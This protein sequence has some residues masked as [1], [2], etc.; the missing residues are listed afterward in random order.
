MT[1]APLSNI[2][3]VETPDTPGVADSAPS[4]GQRVGHYVA[5][6]VFEASALALTLVTGL[7]YVVGR[8]YL[9]G[10]EEAAGVPGLMFRRDLSDVMLGGATVARVWMMPVL[11]AVAPFLIMWV[12]A[13][14]PEWMMARWPFLQLK[15]WYRRVRRVYRSGVDQIRLRQR[16]ADAAYSATR[17]LKPQAR[18]ECEAWSRWKVLG[19]R[20]GRIAER[21][22]V[23]R[24]RRAMR[25]V[26]FVMLLAVVAA[27]A[28]LLG[29]T[30]FVRA[31]LDE[32]RRMGRENFAKIYLAVTGRVPYQYGDGLRDPQELQGWAC[33]GRELLSYY[34]AVT[35]GNSTDSSKSSATYY[36]LQG[37]DH[38]FMLLGEAGSVIRSLGDAPFSLAESN[39]RPLSQLARRC[40][41][42]Q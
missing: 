17:G 18:R 24:P 39:V 21:D 19:P 5:A 32:P 25:R 42:E 13:T 2:E 15:R 37:A 29:Y 33:E 14:V 1:N 31:F 10:W 30:F 3:S 38:T 26:T 12:M 35:L 27:E 11:S 8:S 20:H 22:P 36:L 28:A 16:Y 41:R 6:H 40:R 4:V 34:R 9:N 23:V 7:A